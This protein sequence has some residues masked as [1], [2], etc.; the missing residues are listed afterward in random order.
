MSLRSAAALRGLM[1]LPLIAAAFA[2][3]LAAADKKP[4]YE[5]TH[6]VVGF[7]HKGPNWTAEQTD[8]TRRMQEAHLANFQKLAEAGKLIVAGP[9]SDNGG[10][11]GMLIF[12]LESVDEARTLMDADPTLKAGRLTLEL[13]PWFAAAGLRVDAPKTAP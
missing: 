12:K 7:F 13:H 11:R 1:T 5:M 10:L 4:Q 8:E 6:Y 3:V 9:F 2:I